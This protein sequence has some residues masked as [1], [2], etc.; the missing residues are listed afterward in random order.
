MNIDKHSSDQVIDDANIVETEGMS[1]TEYNIAINFL[2][3]IPFNK[4][5]GLRPTKLSQDYCEFKMQMKDDLIGNFLQGILHGG[6][7]STALDVTGGAMAM[8]AAWQRLKEHKVPTSERPKTLS[9]LGTIDMRVDFL[10]PGKG[11]EFTISSTL[12]RIGN[13]VA[14]TR[15]ELKNENGELI[16]V[17]TGTYLCG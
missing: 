8:I 10:Q 6:A 4:V 9:K 16:S 13:K 11:K 12:L 7:I 14:V 17:G 1:R 15:M 5:L 2:E 3:Q